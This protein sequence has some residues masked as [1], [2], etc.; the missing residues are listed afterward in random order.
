MI[1]TKTQRRFELQCQFNDGSETIETE[2][3]IDNKQC[4][5]Y[6]FNDRD[7]IQIVFWC[8]HHG[9]EIK[10][11]KT[12]NFD[13]FREDIEQ[14]GQLEYYNDRWDYATESVFQDYYI[15][16]WD[17]WLQETGTDYL[18]EFALDQLDKHG[19]QYVK[20][21]MTD[22]IIRF[23]AIINYNLKQCVSRITKQTQK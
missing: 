16:D 21:S 5:I 7:E 18:T 8:D 1:S 9:D 17:E 20:R 13:S 10:F 3:L 19:K 23:C 15:Q 14:R 22:R 2:T 4:S 11:I 6:Y 12:S